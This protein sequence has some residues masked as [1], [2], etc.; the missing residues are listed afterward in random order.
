VIGLALLALIA[1]RQWQGPEPSYSPHNLPATTE[2]A[3]RRVVDGDTILFE[4]DMRVRLIG[5]NAPESVKPESPVEPFGPEA[6][7][8]TKE[9]VRGGVARLEYDRE[10][11]DQYGRP[12]AY[13]WVGD[14]MLNEELLRAGL[15]RWERN[16]NYSGEKKQVFRA[17]EQAARQERR[18]IWSSATAP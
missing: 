14:R 3:V 17:A 6:S 15:A 18:G 5:V 9:F 8:F 16:Y 12:L 13:V 1:Y 11:F 2:L 4:P 7:Q 10:R